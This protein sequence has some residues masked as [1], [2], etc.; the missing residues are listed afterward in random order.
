MVGLIRQGC[1]CEGKGGVGGAPPRRA[2]G[3]LTAL[4]PASSVQLLLPRDV[5]GQGPGGVSRPPGPDQGSAGHRPPEGDRDCVRRPRQGE[6]GR[7]RGLVRKG[8]EAAFRG[9]SG[10]NPGAEA[11]GGEEGLAEGDGRGLRLQALPV[12]AGGRKSHSAQR[13]GQPG[14][15]HEVGGAPRADLGGA[16]LA[17]SLQKQGNIRW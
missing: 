1:T 2:G 15:R 17:L 14:H 16:L 3:A 7:S 8:R 4:H 11:D 13:G 10:F 6:P 12:R 9:F 5:R